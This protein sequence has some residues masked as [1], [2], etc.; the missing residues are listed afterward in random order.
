MIH[1]RKLA[2]KQEKISPEGAVK[3][4]VKKYRKTYEL[5]EK[6]DET[7]GAPKILDDRENIG[8]YFRRV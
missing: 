8:R 3:H 4:S 6:Y 1:L 7:G 5:L 2:K